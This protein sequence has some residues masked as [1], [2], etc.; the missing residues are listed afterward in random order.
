M[1]KFITL[2]VIRSSLKRTLPKLNNR[3][4]KKLF[5]LSYKLF[6]FLKP[7]QL[8]VIVLALL[9]KTEFKKLL[10]IPSIFIL[11]ST[12]FSDSE[13]FN[14]NLSLH[15][16]NAKLDET[17]FNEAENKWE[18]F[19]WVIIIL[20]LITR[21]I[22]FLFKIL[23]VPFYIAFVYYIFKYLGLD[24]TYIFNVLNTITLGIIEWFYEK[25]IKFFEWFNNN[26]NSYN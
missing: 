6:V 2:R 14:S 9:S 7:S 5:T 1:I 16:L 3:L 18:S 19:F 8:W 20:A 10:T 13:P 4:Y 22:N 11:F 25:I 15:T 23:W 24:F 12:L 17:K 21:F 26:E